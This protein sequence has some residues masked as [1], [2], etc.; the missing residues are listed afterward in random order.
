MN[1]E[2]G[3][4]DFLQASNIKNKV[5]HPAFF[6]IKFRSLIKIGSENQ[7]DVFAEE[8]KAEVEVMSQSEKARKALALLYKNEPRVSVRS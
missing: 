8:S 7:A 1:D 6:A 5:K 4:F 2:Q 3:F